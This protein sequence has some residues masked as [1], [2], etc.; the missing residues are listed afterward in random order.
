MSRSSNDPLCNLV[1]FQGYGHEFA[2]RIVAMN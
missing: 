2:Q 1:R